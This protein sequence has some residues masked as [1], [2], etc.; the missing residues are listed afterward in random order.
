MAS[1]RTG[2]PDWLKAFFDRASAGMAV[3][4]A[5]G[6]YLHANPCWLK[7]TGYSLDEI[8]RATLFD[9]THPDDISGSQ[10]SLQGLVSGKIDNYRLER[11][12][13]RKDGSI[14]WG[15]VSASAQRDTQGK[16]VAVILILVDISER[17]EAEANLWLERDLFAGGPVV[18]WKQVGR[19]EEARQYV[20]SNIS[21][22]GYTVED[23]TNVKSYFNIVH[24]EDRQRVRDEIDTH[25]ISGANSYEQEYRIKC[26]DGEI[27]WVHDFTLVS[28]NPQGKVTQFG[29]YIFDV[30]ERKKAEEAQREISLAAEEAR[31]TAEAAVRTQSIFLASMSHEIRT[32]LHGV[33]GMTSLLLETELAQEQQDFVNIIRSS[34]ETL[35]TI[36]NNLLDFSKIEA[37]KLEL[38]ATTFDLRVCIEEIL[39]LMAVKASEKKIE[40]A[41]FMVQS[42]PEVV[43][44]D[45]TR[46]RQILVNLL[47]N[48]IKFTDQGEVVL[49]VS[50]ENEP[51]QQKPP[52]DGI[53]EAMLTTL[54]FVVRD[55]GIGIPE[56]KKDRLFKPFSQLDVSTTRK[57]GGTGLGLAISRQLCDL[58]GGK[59]W[60]ESQGIPGKGSSFH[61][62]IVVEEGMVEY[63]SR[64][65]CKQP[66]MEG[67][68]LLIVDDNAINRMILTH[69]AGL[70][71]A[72]PKATA[73]A[74]DALNWIHHGEVFDLA[75][76]DMQMP[77]IDGIQ[78]A[79]MIHKR[80]EELPLVMLTSLGM[81]GRQVPVD[82]FAG[83]LNKP[84]KVA[85]LYEVLTS[86]LSIQPTLA[87]KPIP[88]R[89]RLDAQMAEKRPIK[90]LL[91]E[92]NPINQQVVMLMLSKLGYE[93]ELVSNGLEA[94]NAVKK[95]GYDLVL[96]DVQMPDM[97]GE[98]ATRRIRAE[99]P[100]KRQP[101]I[102]ALTADALEGRREFYLENGMDDFLSKPMGIDNLVKAIDHYWAVRELAASSAR[103]PAVIAVETL[104]RSVIQREI[105]SEWI[106]AIGSPSSFLSVMDVFLDNSPR[107]VQDIERFYA[108][109]DWKSLNAVTHAFR[110]SSGSM[111]ADQ[112]SNLLGILE[113]LSGAARDGGAIDENLLPGL[114]NQIKQLHSRTCEE[115]RSLQVELKTIAPADSQAGRVKGTSDETIS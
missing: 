63:S 12:F 115:L 90:I 64:Q 23:F 75:I 100:Q 10:E 95:H 56:D 28:R 61:F 15:E 79:E 74:Q 66:Q 101:Y 21:Q 110:S 111:G 18:V 14:F 1:G 58:M 25:L 113:D 6:C 98:E 16:L 13:L 38:E 9:Q 107:M 8:T 104:N 30:T 65:Y 29:W 50:L 37:G 71:G 26:A 80:K 4:D 114:Y 88:A 35:L 45:V 24:E 44:G 47:H 81:H 99:V 22:F 51:S 112:L 103:T 3:L 55:T 49:E 62:T 40:L 53:S 69:F 94:L 109:R 87:A 91:A 96:M 19:G 92:D 72:Y 27:R 7:M 5:Q 57:Y 2:E 34:S 42:V 67:K 85:Q 78:F 46:L 60:V 31:A 93:P 48:A 11:R 59:M 39:D 32:P 68:H 54:H 70:W 83:R 20:S 73:S 36:I 108:A 105:V 84:I 76:L 43:V 77:E 33:I 102:V 106:Q 52:Y 17:R 97:N 89:P 86:V 82:L 41:Y